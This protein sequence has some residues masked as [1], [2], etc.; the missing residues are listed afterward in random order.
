MFIQIPTGYFALKS[1][2]ATSRNV[3]RILFVV[4]VLCYSSKMT[5]GQDSDLILKIMIFVVHNFGE[6]T[7]T[8]LFVRNFYPRVQFFLC[9]SECLALELFYI[10]FF[11]II[12]LLPPARF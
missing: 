6:M 12:H 8:F 11:F 5:M 1:L 2:I 10:L 3:L 4:H 7:N 9:N